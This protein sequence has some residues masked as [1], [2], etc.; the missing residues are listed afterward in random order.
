MQSD[1]DSCLFTRDANTENWILCLY[2][3]DELVACKNEKLIKAFI[4]SLK[5]KFEI[6]CH[7][8]SCYVSIEISHDWK[9]K[10]IYI[11]QQGYISRMLRRF[12]MENSKTAAS[13]MDCSSCR[14]A[15]RRTMRKSSLIEKL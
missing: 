1:S 15:K 8:P 12:E 3:D 6:T 2:V 4:S 14:R 10:T 13:P 7:E 9:S 11:N 5:R